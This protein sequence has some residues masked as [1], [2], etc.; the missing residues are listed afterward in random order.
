MWPTG[1]TIVNSFGYDNR[2]RLY[3]EYRLFDPPYDY[4]YEYDQGGNR[5][6][7]E[8]LLTGEVIEY[9][10]DY[11]DTTKYGPAGN[12]LME[13][14][15][16]EA[17]NPN[18]VSR[19]Y[20]YYNNAANLTRVLTE[21]AAPEPG[22]PRYSATWL[23]YATNGQAVAHVVG[24]HWDWGGQASSVGGGTYEGGH[25]GY[26]EGIILYNTKDLESIISR[27]ELIAEGIEATIN[28]AM[29]IP[30]AGMGCDMNTR[31]G[32]ECG[33]YH[34]WQSKIKRALDPNTASDPFFYAEPEDGE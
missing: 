20:Y 5:T 17:G 30:I 28:D 11:E 12:R 19:T 18:S 15:R 4:E 25:L 1:P 29:G 7:K 33:N 2:G 24:E 21:Q 27:G 23:T 26:L 34:I 16:Y 31:L 9:H 32:P 6:R 14:V 3:R 10:Y 13:S 22:E 8:D